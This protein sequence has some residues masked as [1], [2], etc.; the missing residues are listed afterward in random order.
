VFDLAI[1]VGIQAGSRTGRSA[2]LLGGPGVAVVELGSQ[3]MASAAEKFKAFEAA[4]WSRRAT[5]YGRVS[6]AITAPGGGQL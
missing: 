6:G 2:A 5:T 3:A 4:G 1:A